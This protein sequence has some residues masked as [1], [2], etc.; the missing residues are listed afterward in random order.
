VVLQNFINLKGNVRFG[1]YI[2]AVQ[3]TTTING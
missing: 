3:K 2:Q 1:K